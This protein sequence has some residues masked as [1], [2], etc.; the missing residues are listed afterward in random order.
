MEAKMLVMNIK[1]NFFAD[2]A[3]PTSTPCHLTSEVYLT[4]SIMQLP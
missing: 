1:R 3:I 4:V 2:R